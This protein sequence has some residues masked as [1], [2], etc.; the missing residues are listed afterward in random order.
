MRIFAIVG[1]I[2]AAALGVLAVVLLAAPS[3]SPLAQAAGRLEAQNVR[4]RVEYHFIEDGKPITMAG[5]ALI[6]ATNRRMRLEV[7]TSFPGVD[8]PFDQTILAVG[9][10][11]W[12]HMPRFDEFMPKGKP[13][14]H[15]IEREA[16][17][18]SM[19]PSDYARFVA[20]A[21]DVE[22]KETT[23]IRGQRVT[24]YGGAVNVRDMAKETGGKMKQFYE[25]KLGDADVFVPIEVWV[26]D[27]G[28]PARI[29]IHA[30]SNTILADVLEYD[31]PVDVK[32]PPASRTISEAEFNRLTAD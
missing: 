10:D 23:T 25:D 1:A 27:D 5:T 31:V 29:A 6:E 8:E 18:N 13:W 7:K 20:G 16:G 28:R 22:K 14:V 9:D 3:S 24:H 17:L 30:K 32:P 12:L 15:V 2:V 19:T 11:V 4:L 21:D 26:A